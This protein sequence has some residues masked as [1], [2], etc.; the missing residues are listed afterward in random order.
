MR[1]ACAERHGA[2]GGARCMELGQ[3]RSF[4]DRARRFGRSS[5]QKIPFY[6]P[7]IEQAEIDEVVATLRS[8]WLTTG[9]KT[10]QFERN[11]PGIWGKNMRWQSIPAR[12][13][14]TWPWRPSACTR[15][16]P[17]WCRP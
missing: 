1:A 11:L 2:A 12:R 4:W 17:C 3:A 5:M 15:A 16:R 8:G 13:H 9:P 7:N 10:R 14:C 6:R